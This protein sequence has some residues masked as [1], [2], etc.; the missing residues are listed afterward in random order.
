MPLAV[1]LAVQ[2]A[3]DI[4][5]PLQLAVQLAVQVSTA[6]CPASATKAPRVAFS[7]AALSVR[8]RL[9]YNMRKAKYMYGGN[10]FEIS[11]KRMEKSTVVTENKLGWDEP[12]T[13][14]IYPR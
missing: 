7:A 5:L 11:R 2:L 1:P 14:T 9:S 8:L 3:L 13:T 12:S 10:A 6:N 4:Q